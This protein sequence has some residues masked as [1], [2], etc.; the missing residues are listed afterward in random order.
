MSALSLVGVLAE[1]LVTVSRKV[2]L[3]LVTAAATASDTSFRPTTCS[4]RPP[5][6]GESCQWIGISRAATPAEWLSAALLDHSGFSFS[7]SKS[8]SQSNWR[9]TDE[10]LRVGGRVPSPW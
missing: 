3:Q 9:I 1:F 2:K 5:H 4:S 6:Q 7:A 8:E 10:M